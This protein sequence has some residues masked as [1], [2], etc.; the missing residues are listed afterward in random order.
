MLLDDGPNVLP[1]RGEVPTYLPRVRTGL[2]ISACGVLL[3]LSSSRSPVVCYVDNKPV[4]VARSWQG[5]C[6]HR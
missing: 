2:L 3:G 1:S 5:E 4:T 6:P